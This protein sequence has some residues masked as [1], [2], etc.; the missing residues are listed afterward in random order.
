MTTL[1]LG[2]DWELRAD[3]ANNRLLAEYTPNGTQFEMNEDGTLRPLNGGIDLG[4]ADITNA[5]SVS[6]GEADI[7]NETV[8]KARLG[9]N[10][11]D[12]GSPFSSGSWVVMADAE[13]LDNLDE[14]DGSFNI[15]PNESGW[16]SVFLRASFFDGSDQD[17]I[18]VAVRDV[19]SGLTVTDG[20]L[21]DWTSGS[22]GNIHGT[23]YVNLTAG[24]NY[25]I[26]AS[27]NTSS[28]RLNGGNDKT[29]YD[30][31]RGV[32]HPSSR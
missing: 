11:D 18:R 24:T 25:Q 17:Q 8:V 6:T 13:V 26:Q 10:K 28:F 22:K 30:V 23:V 16:Y 19:D 27:N 21:E 12:G 2:Q 7:T 31:I 32:V 5:G 29:G 1:N 3:A 20:L 9:N 15:N 4:G 14:Q